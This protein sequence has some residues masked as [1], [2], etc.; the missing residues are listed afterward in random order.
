[1]RLQSTTQL[2]VRRWNNGPST[3]SV[4]PHI[5]FSLA[6]IFACSLLQSMDQQPG[7]SSDL[8]FIDASVLQYLVISSSRVLGLLFVRNDDLAGW[9]VDPS[10]APHLVRF[11]WVASK[12]LNL[13]STITTYG[14]SMAS[15]VI[16]SALISAVF[17]I[18][19]L[20]SFPANTDKK[21]IK[22][23]TKRP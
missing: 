23:T 14:S 16:T 17:C 10:V 18:S 5:T 21:Y 9:F 4:G 19:F 1:M 13:Q 8:R 20:D 7:S 22:I 12:S 2:T 11:P 3:A 6:F 15:Y